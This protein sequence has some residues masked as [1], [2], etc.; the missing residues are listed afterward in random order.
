[1]PISRLSS[2][3][4]KFWCLVFILACV[5]LIGAEHV[6]LDVI[7]SS[8]ASLSSRRERVSGT[9]ELPLVVVLSL[10]RLVLTCLFWSLSCLVWSC[11]HL[12]LRCLQAAPTARR[13]RWSMVASARGPSSFFV[14]CLS[15]VFS[16]LL[17]V[18]SLS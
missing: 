9:G 15:F 4:L 2:P 8:R 18:L 7:V 5:F 6:S 3:Y 13:L 14:L 16:G 11:L 12:V 17:F 10:S 1:M